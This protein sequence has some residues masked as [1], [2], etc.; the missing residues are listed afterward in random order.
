MRRPAAPVE[1]IMPRLHLACPKCSGKKT[2]RFARDAV[3]IGLRVAD[4]Q[5]SLCAHGRAA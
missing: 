2:R 5:T 3:R 4:E 1:L